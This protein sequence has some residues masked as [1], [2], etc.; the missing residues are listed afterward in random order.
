MMQMPS[1]L[2]SVVLLNI[3][4]YIMVKKIVIKI[5]HMNLLQY[6]FNRQENPTKPTKPKK[7]KLST[8]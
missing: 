4:E 7:P 8:F 6:N 3:G 1:A 5:S 2:P